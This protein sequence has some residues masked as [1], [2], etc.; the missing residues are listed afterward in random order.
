M[1]MVDVERERE[2]LLK[3]DQ[4]WAAEA[5]SGDIDRIVS[6]W[7]DDAVVLPPNRPPLVGK[8]AIRKFVAESKTIPGFGIS[9]KATRAVIAAAGDMG[10]T[11]ATNRI[12]MTGADGKPAVIK[13]QAVTVWRK[14]PDGS[15]R[16]VLDIWNDGPQDTDAP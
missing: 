5:A 11:V 6:Y 12:T 9:W 3:T 7:S 2:A 10:Y 8:A 4:E 1:N 14:E 16:C 13:G 15:W